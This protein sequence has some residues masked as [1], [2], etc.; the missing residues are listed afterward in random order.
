MELYLKW[1]NKW[2]NKEELL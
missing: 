2:V 1:V